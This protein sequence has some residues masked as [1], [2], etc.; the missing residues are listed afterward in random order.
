MAAAVAVDTLGNQ[1]AIRLQFAMR[2]HF[3]LELIARGNDFSPRRNSGLR[4][5]EHGRE[6]YLRAEPGDH[7]LVGHALYLHN[8]NAMSIPYLPIVPGMAKHR[9]RTGSRPEEVG[10]RIKERRDKLGLKQNDV[11]AAAGITQGTYSQIETGKTKNPEAGTLLNIASALHTS[12]Y[13]IVFD[14]IPPE[15]MEHTIAA[16][17]HVWDRLSA[18]Q[19]LQV[20]AYAQGLV[21][22]KP[23]DGA[24]PV[25]PKQQRP[26]SH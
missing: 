11:A 7:L 1:G 10:R 5:A 14:H 15:A 18:A 13:L 9:P 19:R 12:P 20:I 25:V 24:R 4:D 17:V 22:A 2:Q 8:D 16:M 21:D 23:Q 26:G 6:A 3:K